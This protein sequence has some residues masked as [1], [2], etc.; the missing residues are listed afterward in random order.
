MALCQ[1][2]ANIEQVVLDA[3]YDFQTFDYCEPRSAGIYVPA[4]GD[5]VEVAGAPVWSWHMRE[6]GDV[7]LRPLRPARLIVAA[8]NV[9]EELLASNAACP[10]AG[11]SYED[12]FDIA[13]DDMTG[14]IVAVEPG[15]D[16]HVCLTNE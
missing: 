16:C 9:T 11:S 7:W 13:V 8:D 14:E 2:E 15:L 3:T 4:V 6:T 1:A 10:T 12:G 5:R